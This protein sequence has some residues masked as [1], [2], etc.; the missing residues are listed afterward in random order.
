M[1]QCINIPVFQSQSSLLSVPLS[2]WRASVCACLTA[3]CRRLAPLPRC[4]RLQ[5]LFHKGSIS[6]PASDPITHTPLQLILFTPNPR[7]T[8]A[9]AA[10]NSVLQQPAGSVGLQKCVS[11][12]RDGAFSYQNRRCRHK[13]WYDLHTSSTFRHTGVC[14]LSSVCASEVYVYG[15][16]SGSGTR[17]SGNLYI[18]SK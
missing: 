12:V 13:S 1:F 4:H 8:V 16:R 10:A 5:R 14:F 2:R 7:D 6:W 3:A 11:K 9:I 17:V 15:Q 18:P